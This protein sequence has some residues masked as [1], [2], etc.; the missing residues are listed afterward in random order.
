MPT[1]RTSKKRAHLP[2]K[3]AAQLDYEIDS[4]MKKT[5]ARRGA[6]AA[7]LIAAF[8]RSP[9]I[10]ITEKGGRKVLVVRSGEMQ[11]RGE[12][13][14][15]ATIFG[16]DGPRGH[17]TRNT[18]RE[19]AE[20]LLHYYSVQDVKAATDAE[21][22]R[23]TTSCE[24]DQGSKRVAF[25]QAVNTLSYQAGKA[26]KRARAREIEDRAHE[27]AAANQWDKAIKTLEAGIKEIG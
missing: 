12:G 7:K 8:K 26:D 4:F 18:D 21:V 5:N 25:T 20:E 11:N 1:K 16:S 27:L 23:W 17:I 10:I 13:K 6:N 2:K 24:F 19:L 14:F 22:V 15:R 9:G 3:S